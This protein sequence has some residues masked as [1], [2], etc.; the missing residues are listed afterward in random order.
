[1]PARA[2]LV[3]LVALTLGAGAPLRA[4]VA[5]ADVQSAIG[6]AQQAASRERIAPRCWLRLIR[7]SRGLPPGRRAT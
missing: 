5:E 7:L 2:A 1:M 4:E 6:K 3:S